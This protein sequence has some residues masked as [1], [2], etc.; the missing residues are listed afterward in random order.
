MNRIF[1]QTLIFATLMVVGIFTVQLLLAI[2]N[3]FLALA[4]SIAN[5]GRLVPGTANK[6]V[7]IQS[8][9][10]LATLL[11]LIFVLYL[12]LKYIGAVMFKGASV[13]SIVKMTTKAPF[14]SLG[15]TAK[16]GANFLRG[17]RHL[18]QNELRSFAMRKSLLG[19][20]NRRGGKL[21]NKALRGKDDLDMMK[22]IMDRGAD[23][24]KRKDNL[25]S[26]K[27]KGMTPKDTREKAH[28]LINK[29]NA[30]KLANLGLDSAL[31]NNLNDDDKRNALNIADD[32]SKSL[33]QKRDAIKN[34]RVDSLKDKRD[35]AG[36]DTPDEIVEK[37]AD[38]KHNAAL[39]HG[40]MLDNH[41]NE[42]KESMEKSGFKV[43][44]DNGNE[45]NGVDYINAHDDSAI[46][47]SDKFREAHKETLGGYAARGVAGATTA[48]YA[49]DISRTNEENRNSTV[50]G[51]LN[52][53]YTQPVASDEERETDHAARVHGRIPID[54]EVA[55][56]HAKKAAKDMDDINA[57]E[58]GYRSTG[59]EPVEDKIARDEEGNAVSSFIEKQ[60]DYV[61]AAEVINSGSPH[62]NI[63]PRSLTDEFDP[64]NMTEENIIAATEDN[65][66]TYASGAYH[67]EIMEDGRFDT[68]SEAI[69]EAFAT[70]PLNAN[71]FY[72][73]EGNVDTNVGQQAMEAD[74]TGTDISED[75]HSVAENANAAQNTDDNIAD[76]RVSTLGK[77]ATAGA[78]A[79][80]VNDGLDATFRDN[81]TNDDGLDSTFSDNNDNIPHHD[82]SSIDAAFGSNN[83]GHENNVQGE[84]SH[85]QQ[86]YA[87]Q[88][89]HNNAEETSYQQFANDN[90]STSPV[91]QNND[92]IP[93]PGHNQNDDFHNGHQR[94]AEQRMQEE[95]MRQQEYADR[96]RMHEDEMQRQ[97]EDH[98]QQRFQEDQ[99]RQEENMRREDDMRRQHQDDME[100]R[101]QDSQQQQMY[102]N[103]GYNS[104]DIDSAF[105]GGAT[106]SPA[107][108]SQSYTAPQNIADNFNNAWLGA[109]GAA[110]AMGMAQSVK[111]LAQ[112]V[113]DRNNVEFEFSQ[114]SQRNLDNMLR[115]YKDDLE[116]G[117]VSSM[118]KAESRIKEIANYAAGT[119]SE[120]SR[121]ATLNSRAES[122]D[123]ERRV[124][125]AKDTLNDS[126]TDMLNRISREALNRKAE[127][128]E[129]ERRKNG[130]NAI[131]DE[132][133]RGR[134]K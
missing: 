106:A 32:D 116:R 101:A 40:Q 71:T 131:K 115:E 73:Y 25:K 76:D 117:A 126:L 28:D 15:K 95:N 3:I 100:R 63:L 1:K 103:Q 19:G 84:E 85:R 77:A 119:L 70:Q 38:R 65:L 33:A 20:G 98:M 16:G 8:I 78:A 31:L 54:K 49:L 9:I 64:E 91:N 111:Y 43:Y 128:E 34:L 133:N 22:S 58:T 2:T 125:D 79:A 66:A 17:L 123:A 120:A 110:G 57:S 83:L 74:L 93:Q 7:M 132:G 80:M 52:P 26:L 37:L 118:D 11:G 12:L 94:Y 18:N 112:N 87:Q 39:A 97:R 130:T 134:R 23:G 102:S 55:E 41:V 88:Q 44:D 27:E 122:G 42:G 62:G 86:N 53:A 24:K 92:Y 107:S 114:E 47:T 127:A 45:M 105:G 72:G 82:S 75:A 113:G 35:K 129:E 59:E 46:R 69:D 4:S 121:R 109:G 48:M 67:P 81:N 30:A 6:F 50:N 99:R 104:N 29:K 89:M 96:Q 14:N 56:D 51:S 68:S 10:Q 5:L 21:L 36:Y 90:G 60:D 61:H 124:N 108:A 13:G